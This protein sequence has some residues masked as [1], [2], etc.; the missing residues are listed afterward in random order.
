MTTVMTP[1]RLYD[2]VIFD[3]DGTLADSAGWFARVLN[4]VARRYRFREVRDED[5]ELLRSLDT[6]AVCR[7]LGLPRWKLPFVARHM[8]KLAAR[9]IR[10]IAPFPGVAQL[11]VALDEAGVRLAIVSSN[12]LDN[13]RIVLGPDIARRIAIYA[14][15]ASTFGK[16]DKFRQVLKR[17]RVDPQKAIAI[18]DEV[19]DLEAAARAGIASGAVAWGYAAP[20][21]L[22]THGPTLMFERVE[23]ILPA[24]VPNARECG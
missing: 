9:D 2:L 15:G 21:F 23:D 4:E 12:T 5:R 17:A 22:E 18:G 8:R 20:T 19:R 7:H 6:V 10:K 24:V 3:F 11:V 14:C 13:V 1:H 16:T